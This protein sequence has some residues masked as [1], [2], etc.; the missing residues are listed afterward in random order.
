MD[1]GG[2]GG[3]GRRKRVA[4][5]RRR[6]TRS[7]APVSVGD[8]EGK[9]KKPKKKRMADDRGHREHEKRERN[10]ETGRT[11]TG[12]KEKTQKMIASATDVIRRGTQ[13]SRF[14]STIDRLLDVT[15]FDPPRSTRLGRFFSRTAWVETHFLSH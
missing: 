8:G 6:L 3:G 7:S 5:T 4:R 2:R 11:E 12:S 10:Q 1:G 15:F 14:C 13:T 9:K